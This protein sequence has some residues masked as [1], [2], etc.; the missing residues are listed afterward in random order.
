MKTT[1]LFL[2]LALVGSSCERSKDDKVVKRLG[3]PDYIR[4]EGENE[5]KMDAAISQSK[6]E[7]DATFPFKTRK[8]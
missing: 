8:P 7:I 3:N 1:S 4:V 5:A 6:K 2:I